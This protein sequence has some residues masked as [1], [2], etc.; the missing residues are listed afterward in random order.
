MRDAQALW[1][2]YSV[3]DRWALVSAWA[4]P[5]ALF[6]GDE[7][8]AEVLRSADCHQ[9]EHGGAQLRRSH[10]PLGVVGLA[11]GRNVAASAVLTQLAWACAL[12]NGVQVSCREPEIVDAVTGLQQEL[13]QSDERLS[14]LVG[15][16]TG[17]AETLDGQHAWSTPPVHAVVAPSADVAK[18]V[19]DVERHLR[20]RGLTLWVNHALHHEL[21]RRLPQ[22]LALEDLSGESPEPSPGELR[23]GHCGAVIEHLGKVHGQ[24]ASHAAFYSGDWREVD[25]ACDQALAVGEAFSVNTLVP[26]PLDLHTARARFQRACAVVMARG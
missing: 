13:A 23:L 2:G 8:W 14:A 1:C 22:A 9:V 11:P 21:R 20:A 15:V 6:E 26:A 19:E 12:G 4:A 5:L 10:A 18:V 16:G 7:R 25:R 17:L 24:R 3:T